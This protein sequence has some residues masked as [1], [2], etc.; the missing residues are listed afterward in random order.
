MRKKAIILFLTLFIF[1]ILSACTTTSNKQEKLS[2]GDLLE[3]TKGIRD[4]PSFLTNDADKETKDTYTKVYS[5]KEVLKQI[6]P[7]DG[8]NYK[9]IFETFFYKENADGTLVWNNHAY[10]NGKTLA[11]G[12]YAAA[13][14]KAGKPLAEI[15]ATIEKQ[16][17][18]EYGANDPRTNYQP[19]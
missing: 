14:A 3:T 6:P 8:S 17:S 16:Y 1:S 10:L 18:G 11:V 15:Q 7:Y 19:K 13:L 4:I 2:N 9:S 12:G 5:Y